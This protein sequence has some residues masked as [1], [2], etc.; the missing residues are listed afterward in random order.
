[1]MFSKMDGNKVKKKRR[2]LI[3]KYNTFLNGRSDATRGV[4]ISINGI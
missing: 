1:M 3:L 4:G 2:F